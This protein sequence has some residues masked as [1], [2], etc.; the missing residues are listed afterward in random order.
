MAGRR[1]PTVVLALLV[2]LAACTPTAG[3][4]ATDERAVA[5][6][7]PTVTP[8]DEHVPSQAPTGEA[9]P[10]PTP[11]ASP[12]DAASGDP[13]DPAYVSAPDADGGVITGA[14]REVVAMGGVLELPPDV[15]GPDPFPEGAV[16]TGS[17]VASSETDDKR[18]VVTLTV[19]GEHLDVYGTITD[20][21]V[22]GGWQFEE[23]T[24]LE[25]RGDSTST[26]TFRRGS[27]PGR[28]ILQVVPDDEGGGQRL[29]YV[30]GRP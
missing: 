28:A 24:Y 13:D 25:N 9:T 16:I 1:T 4:G 20:G 14:D 11:S 8:A 29:T 3:T 2:G 12:T 7:Q 27:R 10:S 22:A 26:W 5:P 30:L 17:H 23:A 15:P 21:I 6:P 18:L 19:P